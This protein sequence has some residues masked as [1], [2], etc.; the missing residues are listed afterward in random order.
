LKASPY[1]RISESG[2]V[3]LW[4][5]TPPNLAFMTTSLSSVWSLVVPTTFKCPAYPFTGAAA[6]ITLVTL[7]VELPQSVKGRGTSPRVNKVLEL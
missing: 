2:M 3:S 1:S 7:I 5:G 6:I 4:R